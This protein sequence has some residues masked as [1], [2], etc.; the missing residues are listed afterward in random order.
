MT[1]WIADTDIQNWIGADK[2][3]LMAAGDLAETATAAV[4][5]LIERDLLVAT[6]SDFYDTNG[7]DF[8][9]L[10]HW[11][12]MSIGSVTLDGTELVAAAPNVKGWRMDSFNKRKLVF[13]GWGKQARGMLNVQVVNL[14]A[15][16][17]PDQPVG[18]ATGFPSHIAQALR[19]TASAIFN[20]QAADPN[21]ASESISGVF[22]GTF[23]QTGVGAVP[24]G[25]RSLLNR[26]MRASP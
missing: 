20:S 16:Y 7:T 21:L 5:S 19:L 23:Y 10:N 12:V 13:A 25:A 11:P 22:S 26:E 6:S 24:P 2:I 15:G 3:T 18:S 14:V 4:Q 9:L 8:I 1:A 17:D